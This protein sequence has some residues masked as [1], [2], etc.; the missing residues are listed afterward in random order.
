[1]RKQEIRISV[2]ECFIKDLQKRLGG[3][4]SVE[5]MR[6]AFTLLGWV[7]KETCRGRV[8]LSSNQRG[9]SVKRLKMPELDFLL[10]GQCA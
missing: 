7:G 9:T 6:A 3:I 1:M 5:V 4:S 10:R 8:I 2:D